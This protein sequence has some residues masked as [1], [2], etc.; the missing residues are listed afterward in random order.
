MKQIVKL[1]NYA[2]KRSAGAVF[3]TDSEVSVTQKELISFKN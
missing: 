2:V 1:S 3:W